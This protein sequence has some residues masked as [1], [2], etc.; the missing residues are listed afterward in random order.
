MPAT[1][2]FC[3]AE[4]WWAAK[5]FTLCISH[6]VN[7]TL[8]NYF[9]PGLPSAA[10]CKR[11][12]KFRIRIYKGKNADRFLALGCVW[13]LSQ[14]RF[15]FSKDIWKWIEITEMPTSG[16]WRTEQ[17]NLEKWKKNNRAQPKTSCVSALGGIVL[18]SRTRITV[19]APHTSLWFREE[20]Y[21]L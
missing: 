12:T 1:K 19:P 10:E 11:K 16:N 6:R 5:M 17:R 13:N 14:E 7:T 4:W 8:N 2:P 21:C 3:S 15:A 20:G 18:L 9:P